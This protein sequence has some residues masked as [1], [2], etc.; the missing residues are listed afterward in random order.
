MMDSGG[1]RF[2][3]A[4]ISSLISWWGDAG[5]DVLVDETPRNWLTPVARPAAQAQPAPVLPNIPETQKA[6]PLAPATPAPAASLPDTLAGFHAW[7]AASDMLTIPLAARVAPA[8]DPASGL[9]ML[10]DMP[11]AADVDA[12][13][14][15]AGDAGVLFDRMIAAMGR[16][17]D[18]LYLSA[19]A[20]GRPAGGY[21]DRAAAT[22]FGELARHHV[23]L[24]KPRALLLMGE[25]PSRTFLN[26]GFVEARGRVHDVVLPGGAVPAVATFHP[27]TL[28][29]HPA[30]KKRAWEDLQMLMKIIA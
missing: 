16:S 6:A 3:E 7:L 18:S 12:G 25:A 14:L 1:I 10:V 27:R 24:A 19:M 29:L 26:M 23:A 13:Q 15:L 28:L 4:D 20:P 9:M 17:R 2:S 21:V 22:L 30:Q 8:G 5:V 11:D